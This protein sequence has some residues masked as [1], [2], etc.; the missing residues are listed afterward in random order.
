MSSA[1]FEL[2]IPEAKGLRPRGHWDRVSKYNYVN[3]IKKNEMVRIRNEFAY[4]CLVGKSEGNRL[5]TEVN[6]RII[7]KLILKWF[8][9]CRLEFPDTRNNGG[10]V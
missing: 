10:V 9:Y 8:C 1:G 4:K 3:E 5:D 2:E 6:K 7:L